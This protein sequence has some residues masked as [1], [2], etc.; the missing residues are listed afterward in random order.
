MVAKGVTI[1]DGCMVGAN[2]LVLHDIP[3]DSR[4]FGTPCRVA[5]PASGEAGRQP[6]HPSDVNPQHP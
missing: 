5:G 1:G 3:A 4:A 6:R 2:S